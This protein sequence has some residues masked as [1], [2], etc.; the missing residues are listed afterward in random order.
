TTGRMYLAD[1]LS[2]LLVPKSSF[3][4]SICEFIY[5]IILTGNS[6]VLLYKSNIL[7]ILTYATLYI[8]GVFFPSSRSSSVIPLN[9][10]SLN[11]PSASIGSSRY[12]KYLFINRAFLSVYFFTHSSFISPLYLYLALMIYLLNL[13]RSPPVIRGRLHISENSSLVSSSADA[14]SLNCTDLSFSD[15]VL[16]AESTFLDSTAFSS[17]INSNLAPILHNPWIT[18]FITL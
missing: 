1:G 7:R 12:R 9:S 4:L 17:S 6:S 13:A 8:Y 10:F 15:M 14:I 5:S 16:S 11:I 18:F 3:F 2:T